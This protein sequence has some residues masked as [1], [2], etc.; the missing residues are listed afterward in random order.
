MT[1]EGP[2][3]KS[4]GRRFQSERRFCPGW[5]RTFIA[6]GLM[7]VAFMN[8]G[9]AQTPIRL[10]QTVEGALEEGDRKMADGSYYDLYVF[11]GHRGQRIVI[12]LRSK[13]FQPYLTLMD[14]NGV[15]ILSHSGEHGHAHIR[16]TLAHPG[17][18][19][20]RVNSVR[21]EGKGRYQLQLLEQ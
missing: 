4:N 10:G 1:R 14:E 5:S 19:F 3:G 15:E 11:R 21:R 6:L 13:E 9:R 2:D 17:R 16:C 12:H 20:I 18:Y 7:L 8:E